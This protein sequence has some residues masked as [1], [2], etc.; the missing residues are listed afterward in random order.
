MRDAARALKV[1]DGSLI[2]GVANFYLKHRMTDPLVNR[3][4][5]QGEAGFSRKTTSIRP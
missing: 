5:P 1:M 4:T 3:P 2:L